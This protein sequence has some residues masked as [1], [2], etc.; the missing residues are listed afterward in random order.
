MIPIITT[1]IFFAN[2]RRNIIPKYANKHHQKFSPVIYEAIIIT[3]SRKI[4]RIGKLLD[5]ILF[6]FGR[7]KD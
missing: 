3:V 1:I 4:H 6:I 5:I 2:S 7:L